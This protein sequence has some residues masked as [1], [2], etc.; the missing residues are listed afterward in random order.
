MELQVLVIEPEKVPELKTIENSLNS[1]QNIVGGFIECVTLDENTILYCNDEGKLEG[2][3]GNRRLG[4]DI[5][6][7]TFLICG[8]DEDGGEISLTDEQIQTWSNRFA[9]PEQYDTVYGDDQ[10]IS[11]LLRFV[12]NEQEFEEDWEV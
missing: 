8:I 4:N 10:D 1:L 3:Q 6:A 2:L 9:E 11:H 5:I 12:L 7:G